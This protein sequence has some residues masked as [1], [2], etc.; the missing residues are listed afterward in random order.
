MKL[1]TMKELIDRA[2]KEHYAVPVLISV[3]W[4]QYR[5]FWKKQKK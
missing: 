1:C 5:V 2:H 3:I 4:K